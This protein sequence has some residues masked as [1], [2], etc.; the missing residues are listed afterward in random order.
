MPLVGGKSARMARATEGACMHE[1][2]WS[3]DDYDKLAGGSV[4]ASKLAPGAVSDVA[5][6]D[7]NSFGSPSTPGRIDVYRT[8][9]GTP[10]ISLIVNG[11]QIST[12]GSD[13]EEQ[14][15][16]WGAGYGEILLNDNAGNDQTVSIS[17]ERQAIFIP[18]P[19]PNPPIIIPNPGAEMALRF[20]LSQGTVRAAIPPANVEVHKLAM[21]VAGTL[22]AV[23]DT[24]VA[25]LKAIADEVDPLFPQRPRKG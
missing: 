23:T 1:F 18:Q 17:A 24:E 8:A 10:A 16:L 19:F 25:K 7:T 2:N 6:S 21:D 13:G 3:D 12:Y 20:A 22:R 14:I 5:L 9:A 11:S 4:T 15:R